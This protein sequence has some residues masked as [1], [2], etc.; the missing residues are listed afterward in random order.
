[1]LSALELREPD[2]V[3]V[4]DLMMEPSLVYSILGEKP[5]L[6]DRLIA[7]PRGAK[8]FDRLLPAANRSRFLKKAVVD[9]LTD[10]EL[11]RL[12]HASIEAGA[13]MGYDAVGVIFFPVFRMQDSRRFEDI[14]GRLYE[15]AI[16]ESGFL[17]DPI[18]RGGLID[19]PDAWRALDKEPFFRLAA[20]AN[21]V[22][23]DVQK[24]NAG[25][26]FPFGM[27]STGLFESTWQM[28][29]FDRYVVAVRRQREFVSRV[30]K[31]LEDHI[32]LTFEAMADAGVPG[33][34]YSDD[35]AY[36]TGPMLNPRLL[37]E[38]FDDS[39]RRFVETAHTLG[40]KIMFHSCGNVSGLLEW[41]ADCGFDAVN[42]LEPTAGMDLAEAKRA[43]G[44]RMCL[45]GNID[46]THVLVD[47][48][49]E[50]VFAAVRQAITDAGKGGGYILA[51][52]HDHEGMSLERMRW[53][54]EACR[55]YGR[56]PLSA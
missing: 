42:P 2:R 15:A 34:L 51:P 11:V 26:V 53:M 31:F 44:D 5:G 47:A 6:A 28:M 14:Y 55:E 29:G 54:L 36:R 21:E 8:A 37:K 9:A 24:R 49:R 22:F 23:V 33:V 18:Y 7:D 20:R 46:V 45:V 35:L 43:V 3:P 48:D 4:F 32:C 40:M 27:V 56:Y 13:G 10:Q 1:M 25:R 30:I 12:A 39:Y 38:M 17:G 16:S 52:D 41:F 50:E 19:G